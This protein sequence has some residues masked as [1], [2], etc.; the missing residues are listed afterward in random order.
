MQV[1]A[2]D[3]AANQ[4]PA[5]ALGS[6]RAEPGTMSRPPRPRS[7]HLLDRPTFGRIVGIGSLEGI[8]AMASFFFAYVLAGWRPWEHLAGSGT[9][10]L[11]ATTMTMAGIV[12]AQ[13]GAAMAWRTNRESIRSVGLL[14]NRLLLVGIAV[15]IAMV[16]LLAYTPGLDDVFH[17]SDLSG[18]EWLLLLAWPPFVLGAEELRKAVVRRRAADGGDRDHAKS[19]M[20]TH[21]SPMKSLAVSD[22]EELDEHTTGAH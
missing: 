10:Y 19:V 6:E 8:A 13:I 2:I 18:W 20:T 12:F 1:L 21:P 11:E 16:A 22:K 14:S 17:T 4:I 15:E 7:E 9:L 3:L 5:M